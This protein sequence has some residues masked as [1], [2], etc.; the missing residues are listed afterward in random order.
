MNGKRPPDRS[1]RDVS[2][3]EKRQKKMFQRHQR[4]KMAQEQK[5]AA[6]KRAAEL[7]RSNRIPIEI[8]RGASLPKAGEFDT[9]S[10]NSICSTF[11]F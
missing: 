7:V 11:S 2:R 6:L 5:Q 4:E 8:T 3:E 10:Q 1:T 9:N